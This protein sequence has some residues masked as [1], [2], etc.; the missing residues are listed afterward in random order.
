MKYPELPKTEWVLAM[1]T[2]SYL[3]GW[4]SMEAAYTA[5]DMMLYALR[6]VEEA[7]REEISAK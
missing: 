1:P 3:N 4:V 2:Q 6:A 7:S 5:E